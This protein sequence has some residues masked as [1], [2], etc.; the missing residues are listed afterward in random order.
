MIIF[1]SGNVE[2]R[3]LS[4]VRMKREEW[5]TPFSPSWSQIIFLLP[6]DFPKVSISSQA[7]SIILVFFQKV[8]S[9]RLR[10][11]DS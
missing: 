5:S 6:Q 7:K 3:K 10:V 2:D 9:L 4:I 1:M 8:K 11:S